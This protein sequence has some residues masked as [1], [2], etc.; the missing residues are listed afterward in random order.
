MAL[1]PFAALSV[2]GS[3]RPAPTAIPSPS[4]FGSSDTQIDPALR[5]PAFSAVPPEDDMGDEGQEPLEDGEIGMDD[6][7]IV[8]LLNGYFE[9]AENARET[10]LE[11]RHD[12]WEQNL[13]AFWMRHDFTDKQPW[14][15]R[16]K[17]SAV[18]SY[19]ER[20]AAGQREALMSDPNWIEIEDRYDETGELGKFATKLTRLALDFAGTNLSGQPVAF[21]HDFGNHVLTGT[22]MAMCAAVTWDPRN[23]RVQIEQRDPRQTYLD[24][25]GRGLYRVSFW[26]TD[27]ETLLR[28]AELK[29]QLGEPLYDAEAIEELV[30]THSLDVAQNLEDSSGQGAH[31][32]SARTPILIKEWLVD[33]IDTSGGNAEKKVVRERQL[34]V[35]ANDSVII[36]GPEKNP[37]WHGKDWVVFHTVL[38]SPMKSVGGRTYVE[39]F[40]PSVQT[41][42]NVTNRI[43]DAFSLSSL[44]AFEVNPDVLDD[45]SALEEGISPNMTIF[46][47]PDAPAGD[48]AVR[49]IE[50][51]RQ[52]GQDAS[53]I[54]NAT[55]RDMQEAGGQSDLSL[56]Q[57]A[58]GE[59][60]ATEAQLSNAGQSALQNSISI[61]IDVAYLA[62]ICE[63]V[64]YT[65]L[66]H[67]GS[68]SK[69]IWSALSE[70][71]QQMLT[72]R[73]SE[74]KEQPIQVR[75]KGLTNS[76]KRK[77]R[78][79]GLTGALNVIGGNPVLMQ[80]YMK[81]YSVGK[82]VARLLSD[83]GVDTNDLALSS[84]QKFQR[85]D[86]IRQQKAKEQA[87][88]AMAGP[89]AA[90]AGAPGMEGEATGG[91]TASQQGG[92]DP[93]MPGVAEGLAGD[94]Q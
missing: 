13:N 71:E 35:T 64:Y 70:D 6:H 15:S 52:T 39:T 54:W 68:A 57:T 9:E 60:T 27:K 53:N 4:P 29:N 85:D 43:L 45:P 11:P 65:A 1:N 17:S 89:M 30:A 78:L 7:E 82:L 56:G 73:R 72:A 21:E 69:G 63:L 83:F 24:P 18:A 66:Q 61:D 32:T 38:Q 36:R 81:D 25:T 42:E 41:H 87:A 26:E 20:F 2:S 75:A 79:R 44:N 31:L 3:P 58:R 14:Q 33:L 50:L 23:G 49:P 80:E 92:P 10:G 74:F 19:C 91:P 46:R 22:L 12:V 62:P 84:D 5:T 59:T 90:M 93:M 8:Q 40:R 48:L 88:A 51:G 47:D 34:I 16:E 77:Q 76:V 67:V 55:R 37:Y 86:A 28:M 94:V